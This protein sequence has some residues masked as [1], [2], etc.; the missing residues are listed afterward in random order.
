M[1]SRSI[2][3]VMIL[4]AIAFGQ[5]AA[6][7]DA[8]LIKVPDT[9]KYFQ[10]LMKDIENEG[11]DPLREV[12]DAMDLITPQAT[13]TFDF[14]SNAAGES[15]DRWT[16]QIGVS[17]LSTAVRQHYG[18][19]YLGQNIWIFI[20][21]DFFRAGEDLWVISNVVFDTEPNKVSQPILQF[22]D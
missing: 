15:D 4:G 19:A 5:T 13:A 10:N 14:L 21:I 3:F 18:Y 1:F 6:A 11:M 17:T 2:F 16:E 12:F 22:L 20:R 7:D 8:N 9:E